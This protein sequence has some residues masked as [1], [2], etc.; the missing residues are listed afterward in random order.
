[1]G[2]LVDR[3]LPDLYPDRGQVFSNQG[4]DRTL[5]ETN[6]NDYSKPDFFLN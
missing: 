3:P 6:F 4:V 2:D 5:V 1:M